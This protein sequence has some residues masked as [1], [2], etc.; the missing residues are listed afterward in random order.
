VERRRRDRSTHRRDRA[1]AIGLAVAV[2]A[3]LIAARADGR[4][5]FSGGRGTDPNPRWT[6]S[7]LPPGWHEVDRRLTGV[8]IPIQVFAA[9][10]YP[11]VL[12]H[13]PGQCG[14]PKAI[15]AEMPPDGALLQVIEYPPRA[16]GHP[17]RVPRLPRR[18]ARFTWAD[19]TWAPFECAGP[20]YKFTYRQSGHALQAQ[21]WMHRATADPALRAGA[22]RILNRLR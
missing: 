11:I 5:P 15:L 7:P 3:L 10:T 14:P 19:A 20:S 22:L 18:P 12:H 4:P 21:V 9:A 1:I 2:V 13:R 8:L 17:L 16:A 6:V